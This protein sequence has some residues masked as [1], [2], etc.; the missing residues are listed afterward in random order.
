[1]K[2]YL[3]SST[4]GATARETIRG[5]SCSITEMNPNPAITHNPNKAAPSS[6]LLSPSNEIDVASIT[7]LRA[8]NAQERD[9]IKW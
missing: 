1:M 7:D 2:K 5:Y 4:L 3:Q 9:H 8:T 6:Q